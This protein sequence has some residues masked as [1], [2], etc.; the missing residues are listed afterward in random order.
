M[1]TILRGCALCVNVKIMWWCRFG[2][3][4]GGCILRLPSAVYV[5]SM[6]YSSSLSLVRIPIPSSLLLLTQPS[7]ML[8]LVFGARRDSAKLQSFQNRIYSSYVKCVHNHK[9]CDTYM[10]G[11]LLRLRYQNYR[12]SEGEAPQP[13][14][15]QSL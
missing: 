6:K 12:E 4:V 3:G 14:L 5:L 9:W 13:C 11:T 8:L 2:F 15:R 10:H 1:C 7:G